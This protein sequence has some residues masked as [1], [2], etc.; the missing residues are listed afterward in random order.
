MKLRIFLTWNTKL[1]IQKKKQKNPAFLYGFKI[2]IT[3]GT[4]ESCVLCLS[5]RIPSSKPE[6]MMMILVFRELKKN[7]FFVFPEAFAL[8]LS[9]SL[10]WFYSHSMLSHNFIWY[11]VCFKGV[12]HRLLEEKPGEKPG[13]KQRKIEK[14]VKITWNCV[15]IQMWLAER[16][17]T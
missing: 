7:L 11:L 4:S 2:R 9:L 10:S 15:K 12:T 8:S 16:S 3:E 6:M 1:R 14:I 5:E 17:S 13:E